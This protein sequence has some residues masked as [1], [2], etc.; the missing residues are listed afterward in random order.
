MT[1]ILEAMM[2]L[3]F[4]CS[5]PF[6]I[7]N[8]YRART[9]K[10]KS[11]FFLCMLLFGYLCGIVWKILAFVE[12]HEFRYPTVFYV[13]NFIMISIDLALYFRNRRLDRAAEEMKKE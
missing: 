6:S 10:G 11:I 13:L 5:W 2:V 12:T 8:S 1:E 7:A 9:A 4:G 3:S